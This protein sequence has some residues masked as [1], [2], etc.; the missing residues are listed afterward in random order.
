MTRSR[1]ASDTRSGCDSAREADINEQP[2]LRATSDNVTRASE[3]RR[4][5]LIAGPSDERLECYLGA[6]PPKECAG[7]LRRLRDFRLDFI[8]QRFADGIDH[9]LDRRLGL[10][11]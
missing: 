3:R 10:L 8:E 4:R 6:T 9:S 2:A 5:E 1:S 7:S 11:A